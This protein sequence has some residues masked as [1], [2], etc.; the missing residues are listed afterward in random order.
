MTAYLSSLA[1]EAGPRPVSDIF[2][3]ASP[4]ESGCHQTLYGS[5]SRVCCIVDLSENLSPETLRNV[6]LP[7]GCVAPLERSQ[8][9]GVLGLAKILEFFI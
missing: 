2:P 5:Y 3:Y 6:W 1:G 7:G 4:D 8:V 9:V